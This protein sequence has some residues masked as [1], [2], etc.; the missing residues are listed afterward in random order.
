[1]RVTMA[2]VA[3]AAGVSKTLVSRVIND[4]KTLTIP[5]ETR[6]KIWEAVQR[7]GYIPDYAAR[8]LARKTTGADGNKA[9]TIGYVTYTSFEKIGH[10]YFSAILQG[11]EEE[12]HAQGCKLGMAFTVE[13]LTKKKDL[14]ERIQAEKMDGIIYLGAIDRGF[15][16][17]LKSFAT[18]GVCLES[19]INPTMDFVGTPY[20]QSGRMAV[21]HLIAAGYRDIGFYGKEGDYRH[22]AY[23]TVLE[24][25]SLKPREDWMLDAGYTMEQAYELTKRN[26]EERPPPEAIFASN[27]EMAIGCMRAFIERGYR[28][29]QDIALMGHDDISMAAFAGVPLSTIRIHKEEIG[30]MAVKILIDRVKTKRKI[31]IS[32][33]FPPKLVV[34]DSCGFRT[35][36]PK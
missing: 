25:H 19:L 7:H 29:P 33:Q 30:R 27:D 20:D 35:R 17:M 32:V 34:R 5:V 3:K 24:A 4:D 15:Y 6:D 36:K 28:I 14:R 23:R 2:D 8:S 21:E 31:P 26:L 13:E 1:M 12:V 9:I 18:Y 11:V 22:Q 10:P 16:E